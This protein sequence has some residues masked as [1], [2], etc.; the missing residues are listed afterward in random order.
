MDAQA[1]NFQ[2][3]ELSCDRL[4]FNLPQELAYYVLQQ[5]KAPVVRRSKHRNSGCLCGI[6]SSNI[7]KVQVKRHK[8]PLFIATCSV[9]LVIG[10]AS[11]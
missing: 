3:P 6:E 9:N 8:A 5:G 11:K 1:S 7:S 10:S 2:N 4:A